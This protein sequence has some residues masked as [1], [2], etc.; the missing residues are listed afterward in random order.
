M[1][2]LPPHFAL[3]ARSAAYVRALTQRIPPSPTFALPMA[4]EPAH[5]TRRLNRIAR[6]HGK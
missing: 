3:I 4:S 5:E 1:T 2:S 6:C